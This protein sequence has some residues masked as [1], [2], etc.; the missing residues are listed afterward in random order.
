[1]AGA[2]RLGTLRGCS[3]EVSTAHI[4]NGVGEA[5]PRVR[6][7]LYRFRPARAPGAAASA[8]VPVD[9]TA[10]LTAELEPLIAA[11]EAHTASERA[12]AT[13]EA[14]LHAESRRSRRR[15]D[16]SSNDHERAAALRGTHGHIAPRHR[17]SGSSG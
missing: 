11:A 2:H 8:G 7:L 3:K 10:E 13:D 17:R 9:R 6:D 15:S 14:Q 5:M 4:C 1:M 16:R 12:A